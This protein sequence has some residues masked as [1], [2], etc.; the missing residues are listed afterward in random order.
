M[1]TGDDAQ[2]EAEARHATHDVGELVWPLEAR[3]V[4]E[5]R[6]RGEALCP[7]AG[8]QRSVDTACGHPVLGPRV[9]Q[10]PVQGEARE[11]LDLG[12]ALEDQPGDD[13]EAVAVGLPA[14]HGREVPTPGWR[15]A[16]H[17]APAV[18]GAPAL[19]DPPDGPDGR[20]RSPGGDGPG[21]VD[22][23]R[24]VLAERAC[25]LE[26]AAQA[27]HAGFDL[28]RR[29]VERVGDRRMIRPFDPVEVCPPRPTDPALDGAQAHPKLPGH[30]PQRVARSNR[31][32]HSAATSLA[33]PFLVMSP[34]PVAAV[35]SHYT[36][37]DVVAHEVTSRLWHLAADG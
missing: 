21:P 5:L 3:V 13:V 34:S 27:Q 7:P 11:D 35:S 20:R 26:L 25:V 22:G 18:E 10:A 31:F 12:P 4:V 9:R 28:R 6:I 19:E 17:P 16:A 29:P 8:L 24:P 14:G 23:D 32:H 2:L 15:R 33:T 30:R 1:N 37:L 36:D